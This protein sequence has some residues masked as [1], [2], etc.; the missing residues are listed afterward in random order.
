MDSIVEVKCSSPNL[1]DSYGS[2]VIYNSD[3][4][5]ITNAHVV[6]YTSLGEIKMFETYEI[7]FARAE[8]YKAAEFIRMDIELDL[9]ILKITEEGIYNPISF[10]E[11]EYTYGDIVYAIGNTSNYGIG[12]SKGIISVP[13]VNVVYNE[14]SRLVIQADIDI[15]SGNSGGALVDKNGR[16]IGVTTF[17]TKDL[18]NN[19]NYGFAYSIPVKI[20]KEYIGE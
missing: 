8:D 7:R 4:Y 5:I 12:I 17:R 3:G 16:L 10:S 20:I 2:G 18:S 19:V 1:G 13:E 6:S 14:M 11:E 9:A 15:A